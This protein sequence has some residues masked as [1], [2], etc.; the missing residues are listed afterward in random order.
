MYKYGNHL[1]DYGLTREEV[2]GFFV[3]A[4]AAPPNLA[5]RAGGWRRRALPARPV[6]V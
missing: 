6:L 1:T 3:D 2:D 4:G 5:G